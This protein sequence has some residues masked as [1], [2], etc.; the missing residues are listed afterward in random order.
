MLQTGFIAAVFPLV[1]SAFAG[2]TSG[3]MLGFLN[4]ARFIGNALGPLMGTTVLAYSNFFSLSMIIAVL[5]IA[6]LGG[7]L[8]SRRMPVG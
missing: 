4:S 7:F 2:E 6:C 5:S 8:W 1:I 3:G